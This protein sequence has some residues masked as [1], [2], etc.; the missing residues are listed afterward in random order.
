M[1]DRGSVQDAKLSPRKS[2]ISPGAFPN[3]LNSKQEIAPPFPPSILTNKLLTLENVQEVNL[4]KILEKR[5]ALHSHRV[6][7]AY[8]N[9]C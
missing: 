4:Q 5:S 1:G 2:M 9:D 6:S 7:D 8:A 3:R